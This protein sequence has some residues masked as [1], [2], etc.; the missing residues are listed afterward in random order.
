MIFAFTLGTEFY[1]DRKRTSFGP[2]LDVWIGIGILAR[3]CDIDVV[4]GV[5]NLLGFILSEL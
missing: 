1:I 5:L 4:S 2:I 3:F